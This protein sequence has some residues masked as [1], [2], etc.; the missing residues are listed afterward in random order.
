ME[1]TPAG[2][3]PINPINISKV[4]NHLGKEYEI[5]ISVDNQGDL[6]VICYSECGVFIHKK[7]LNI[8]ENN[9]DRDTFNSIISQKS[10]GIKLIG[11]PEKK[12]NFFILLSIIKLELEKAN[13]KIENY[14]KI[15][16][17]ILKKNFELKKEIQSLKKNENYIIIPITNFV[18][19]W[20]NYGCGFSS[21]RVFK[22]GKK[23]ELTGLCKKNGGGN[24][25]LI[26]PENCRPKSRLIFP[27]VQDNNAMRIDILPNGTI[28]YCYCEMKCDWIS[29]DGISF[30]TDY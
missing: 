1:A 11:D 22:K 8:I 15:I 26:L 9:L 25:I 16:E 21:C 2:K 30:L 19:G 4:Y 12:E 18:K 24:E 17:Y 29:L 23:I 28:A 6:E 14:P 13:N 20:N 10:E 3:E 7:R 27:M 5:N